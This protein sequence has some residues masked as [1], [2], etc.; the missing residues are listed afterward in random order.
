[1]KLCFFV[2]DAPPHT[3]QEIKGIDAQMLTYV[4]DAAKEGIRMIPLAAS[5]VNTETEFLLRSWAAMTGG[6]YTFLT[7]H[8][9]YGD[10][11][12][13]PTIGEYKVE[14]LNELMIRVISEYCAL[15]YKLPNQ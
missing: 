12:L 9:G 2:L 11:H 13:E 10:S 6:T 14:A 5:G 7:D 15:P 4:K 1:V 8:S 3:N